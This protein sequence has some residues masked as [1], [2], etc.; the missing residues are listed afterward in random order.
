MLN[1]ENKHIV[2]LY[3]HRL[4][5]TTDRDLLC[6]HLN[7]LAEIY[8]NRGSKVSI[9]VLMQKIITNADKRCVKNHLKNGI[10][11]YTLNEWAGTN[12]DILFAKC[13]DDLISVMINQI[14]QSL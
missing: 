10:S 4:C 6:C 14:K 2:F 11:F 7:E 8:R 13:D 9:F 12:S 1:L 3:H 5:D